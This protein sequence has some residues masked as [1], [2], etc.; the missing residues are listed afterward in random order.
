MSHIQNSGGKLYPNQANTMVVDCPKGRESD[1]I[2]DR[3]PRRR[4]LKGAQGRLKEYLKRSRGFFPK[5]KDLSKEEAL[6]NVKKEKERY[7][8]CWNHE[9][10]I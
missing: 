3:K 9:R 1:R 6:V 5:K 8:A 10:G 4:S 2:G 7:R